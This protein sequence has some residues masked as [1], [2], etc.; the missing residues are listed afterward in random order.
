MTI[1]KNTLLTLM[2]ICLVSLGMMAQVQ[3]PASSP[4]A[5]HEQQVGLTNVTLEYSRPSAKGRTIFAED[6]LV[7]Y[8]K[9]WR[10][11]AN[12]ATKITFGDDVKV[13]G[14]ELKAGSYAVLT[15]P[16]AKSWDVMF[17]PYETGNWGS[18]VEMEPAA[19]V[20]AEVTKMTPVY[21]ETFDF[22]LDDLTA[23][24]ASIGFVWADTYAG[25]QLEVNTDAMVMKSIEQTLAG[26]T[27]ND[28][29]A[30]GAYYH[31]SGKDLEKALEWVQKATKSGTPRYWQV[32]KESLI[33]ADLGRYKDA[34]AAAKQSLE[35]AK[36]AGNDD[37]IRMN[38]KSIEMWMK[39]M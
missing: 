15:I 30:A 1:M 17:Y 39:K 12:S 37:Y 11:G 31:D 21:V 26:P 10:T 38:E 9:I 14:K 13:G 29:Y 5:K 32:R 25:L 33:L 28:Y 23:N 4:F 19:T 6:G 8:G 24:G 36:E 16:N 18:Y 7:P 27:V 34:V 35:L 20:K 2:T 22:F 3:A